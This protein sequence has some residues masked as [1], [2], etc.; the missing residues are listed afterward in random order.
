MPA[1]SLS[2]RAMPPP[3]GSRCDGIGD[4]SP[5][6]AERADEGGAGASGGVAPPAVQGWHGV[7]GWH[8]VEGGAEGV[9]ERRRAEAARDAP[10]WPHASCAAARAR[11][12]WPRSRRRSRAPPRTSGWRPCRSCAAV[13]PPACSAG[14]ESSSPPADAAVHGRHGSVRSPCDEAGTRF[15]RNDRCPLD[16]LSI[17]LSSAG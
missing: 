13:A 2:R 11:A 14:S 10:R 17:W 3:A 4:T 12:A 5:C 6:A 7:A 9:A 15:R 16:S 8:G 1:P